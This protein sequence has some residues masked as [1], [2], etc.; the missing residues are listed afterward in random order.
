MSL[1]LLA[2]R[3]ATRGCCPGV[4]TRC[5][6]AAGAMPSSGAGTE[7]RSSSNETVIGAFVTALPT[8]VRRPMA[9]AL[10]SAASEFVW[11]VAQAAGS[12]VPS[13]QTLARSVVGEAPVA[14][15]RTQ[16]PWPGV[17]ARPLTCTSEPIARLGVADDAA[18]L[19][20]DRAVGRHADDRAVLV[21][22]VLARRRGRPSGC[23][24]R[25]P[26]R[27]RPSTV[28]S[29]SRCARLESSAARVMAR[30]GHDDRADAA[31][32]VV[33]GERRRHGPGPAERGRAP[34]VGDGARELVAGQ[35][36]PGR[37][38]A[39]RRHRAVERELG[40]VAAGVGRRRGHEVR[41][42]TG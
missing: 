40:G 34:R 14:C 22:A 24:R 10:W 21:R 6:G 9:P 31:V 16:M 12:S 23:R 20:E 41:R 26:C 28:M 29:T 27:W 36:R 4:A 11:V 37:A 15:M 1:S 33:V 7:A 18:E 19:H 32:D 2:S 42:P 8:Y 5:C 35:Q 25:R 17:C 39:R 38:V 30:G 13:V 3:S